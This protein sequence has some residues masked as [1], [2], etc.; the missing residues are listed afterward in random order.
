MLLRSPPPNESGIRTEHLGESM[1]IPLEYLTCVASERILGEYQ[2]KELNEARNIRK[3]IDK[4]V[5]E[6]LA[7]MDAAS[8][9]LM[10]RERRRKILP[11]LD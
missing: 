7:H 9:A 5:T 3:Q 1:D 4:L 10:L 2:L 6:Y 8:F 11:L